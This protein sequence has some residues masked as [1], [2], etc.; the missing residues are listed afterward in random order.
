M[1]TNTGARSSRKLTGRPD[2]DQGQSSMRCSTGADQLIGHVCELLS[3]NSE[4]I[5][6]DT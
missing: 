5:D 6:N 1:F 2:E 3:K 4:S